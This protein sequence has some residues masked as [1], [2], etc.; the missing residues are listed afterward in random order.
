MSEVF[1]GWLFIWIQRR[2]VLERF[3]TVS[4]VIFWHW[5]MPI[6]SG[7][8]LATSHDLTPNGGLVREFPLFQGNLGW[9]NIIICPDHLSCA[10]FFDL[11][12]PSKGS[13]FVSQNSQK[14]ETTPHLFRENQLPATFK[15]CYYSSSTKGNHPFCETW[16]GTR[17]VGKCRSLLWHHYE[18]GNTDEV[19]WILQ[20]LF[21]GRMEGS[22]FFWVFVLMV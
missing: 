13:G 9:W 20:R 4:W 12:L 6:I 21:W 2:T 1:V 10:Y 11:I 17:A 5:Q 14:R 16:G 7:Q 19:T 8:I 15:P 3:F 18:V 22:V